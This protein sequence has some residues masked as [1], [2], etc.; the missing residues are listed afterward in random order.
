[1]GRTGIIR[2]GKESNAIYWPNHT[3]SDEAE[4]AQYLGLSGR[5]FWQ[6]GTYLGD[7]VVRE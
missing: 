6:F 1:M 5:Y 4:V 2:A 7:E 3:G